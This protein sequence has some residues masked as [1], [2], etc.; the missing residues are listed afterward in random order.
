MSMGYDGQRGWHVDKDAG[1]CVLLERCYSPTWWPDILDALK[2]EQVFPLRHQ[3]PDAT[4]D[5]RVYTVIGLRKSE[6]TTEQRWLFD[7]NGLLARKEDGVD[8]QEHSDFRKVRGVRFAFDTSVLRDG[9]K[10]TY[11]CKQVVVDG[12]IVKARFSPTKE[13]LQE[14]AA[15]DEILRR[16]M[17]G[18]QS[19]QAGLKSF[20]V[21]AT[22]Y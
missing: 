9:E 7:R 5:G 14:F 10:Q 4:I 11:R 17:E 16:S 12:Q 21:Q 22:I 8:V 6:G 1:L 20:R 2:L 19:S 3:L 15:L 13:Q 18:D